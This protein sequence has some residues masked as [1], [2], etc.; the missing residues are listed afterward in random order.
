M[1]RAASAEASG[2][3]EFRVRA[4]YAKTSQIPVTLKE[5]ESVGRGENVIIRPNIDNCPLLD[6][7]L[8]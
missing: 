1:R 8:K 2:K 3:V 5:V 7:R 6:T 4:T